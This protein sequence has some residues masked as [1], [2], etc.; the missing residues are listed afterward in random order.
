MIINYNKLLSSE[1]LRVLNFKCLRITLER[2]FLIIFWDS[3]E[4]FGK[5]TFATF[6][7]PNLGM[8]DLAQPKFG[9]L[10]SNMLLTNIDP[11]ILR[12][13]TRVPCAPFFVAFCWTNNIPLK[14]FYMIE[15]KSCSKILSQSKIT[16]LEIFVKSETII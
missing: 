11:L 4:L 3:N 14:W 2:L 12:G 7:L 6:L 16:C 5:T 8:S 1:H 13:W 9:L 15:R 10:Q